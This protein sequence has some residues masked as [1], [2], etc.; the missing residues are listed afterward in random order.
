MLLMFSV[1]NDIK[2]TTLKNN[3]ALNI[4]FL[5]KP[6]IGSRIPTYKSEILFSTVLLSRVFDYQTNQM[7]IVDI[8]LN[9]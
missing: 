1:W 2:L 7:V 5:D 4:I 8:S 6:P 9:I 3:K